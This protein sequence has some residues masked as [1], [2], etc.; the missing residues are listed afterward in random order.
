MH[1]K[2]RRE[3]VAHPFPGSVFHLCF[4]FG[5]LAACV[6]SEPYQTAANRFASTSF[7]GRTCV[8]L[9]FRMRA[10]LRMCQGGCRPLLLPGTELLLLVSL[11]L[12]ISLPHWS[13]RLSQRM[14]PLLRR[15]RI[16]VPGSSRCA[17]FRLR[18][19]LRLPNSRFSL[20][21]S[22]RPAWL[23]KRTEPVVCL[24]LRLPRHGSD[25]HWSTRSLL[26]HQ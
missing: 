26:P 21:L 4:Q 3:R 22:S 12:R 19:A 20:P 17:C 5:P 18:R 25:R 16:P 10:R 2:P 24:R 23:A 8:R 1:K 13:H 9:R 11:L 7:L 14:R 15:L 6:A